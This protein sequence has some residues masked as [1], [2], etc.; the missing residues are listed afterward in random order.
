M[1]ENQ[2]QPCGWPFRGGIL[3]IPPTAQAACRSCCR[4]H[5]KGAE[6]RPSSRLSES[7]RLCP[8]PP[9]RESI[10]HR[11]LPYS[12]GLLR[13]PPVS[14]TRP[15]LKEPVG[16]VV[17]VVEAEVWDGRVAK[18]GG[19][20][21]FECLVSGVSFTVHQANSPAAFRLG[22]RARVLKVQLIAGAPV[23][24]PVNQLHASST[25]GVQQ[26][27]AASLSSVPRQGQRRSWCPNRSIHNAL[28]VALQ[29]AV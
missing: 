25:V 29:Q 20:V 5:W 10:K 11:T 1:N 14:A 8:F 21:G 12:E 19:G 3:S 16:I 15:T 6:P 13:R 4:R 22:Q 2:V 17:V 23:V 26:Q 27:P 24:S 7:S 9:L 28:H 18:M